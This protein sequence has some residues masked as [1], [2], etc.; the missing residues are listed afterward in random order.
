M[1]LLNGSKQ[2][3]LIANAG[4]MR[5]SAQG[6]NKTYDRL[7][8]GATYARPI[9]SYA[10]SASL[11]YYFLNFPEADENNHRTDQN[12]ALATAISKPVNDWFTWGVNAGYTDNASTQTSTYQYQKLII[13][14][15]ATFNTGF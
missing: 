12:Y 4:F 7:E 11:N 10:W 15:T 9:G 14:T 5:N 13:M 2:E 3:A 8:F 6:K 1:F